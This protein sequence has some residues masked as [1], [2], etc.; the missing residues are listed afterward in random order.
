VSGLLFS[1]S[2]VL[3][4]II[5]GMA[6]VVFLKNRV[7]FGRCQT[8]WF[9]LPIILFSEAAATSVITIVLKIINE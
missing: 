1:D 4:P 9:C 6:Q 8:N 2:K 5:T 7:S 3:L